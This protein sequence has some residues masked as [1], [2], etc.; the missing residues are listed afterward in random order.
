MIPVK[1]KSNHHLSTDKLAEIWREVHYLIIDEISMV[2]KSFLARI[3]SHITTACMATDP[4][5][6]I[7]LPLG[8]LNIGHQIYKHFSMVMILKEQCQIED[9]IWMCFLWR[10]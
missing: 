2:S 10:A 8:R 3:S 4:N 6:P 1:A 7:D 5:A 9:P